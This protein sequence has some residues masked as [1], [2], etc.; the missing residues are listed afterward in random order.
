MKHIFV[1]N[2]AAGRDACAAVE[3]LQEKL[4][5]YDGQLTYEFYSTMCPGDA[6][7]YVRS[8]CEAEPEE[9]L[10]FYACG[11]DGTANEVLHGVVGM[12]NASMT[13]YPCGSGNDYVKY[14]GGKERFLD[15]DALLKGSEHRVDIMRIGDRYALNATHFG[16]DTAV[17][18]TMTAVRHKKLIG[19][20]NAYTTGIVKALFTAMKNDCTVYVDGEQINEG[21]ILLC[22]VSNGKYVGGSFC[23]APHSQNDDGL[24]EICLVKPISRFTFVKLI[25]VYKKGEHLDDP[26]FRN[27]VAYRRG[28]SVRISAPKGFAVSIDGEILEQS[29]L[30]VEVCPQA[31]RFVV[32]AAPQEEP[33]EEKAAELQT[34]S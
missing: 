25:S 6:G 24:L 26:R 12:P 34:V 21:K 10:R 3:E 16:F 32:P 27:I 19:C 28:R 33:T 14:Y 20:R 1:H 17:A 2:P 5:A 31:I 15:L 11:G 8:R 30:T 18:R 23:C 9:D 7:R 29:E 4:R 22:T 13:C